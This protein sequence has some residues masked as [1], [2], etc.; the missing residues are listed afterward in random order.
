[1]VSDN[2]LPNWLPKML[3][4]ALSLAI[5]TVVISS[6]IRLADSGLGCTPWPD[7]YG[8]YLSNES[9]QGINVL[10]EEGDRSNYRTERIFHRL[11]ASSLGLVILF[12]FILSWR[13]LYRE[14]LGQFV[15]SILMLLTT[16]LAVI[17]PIRPATPLPILTVANFI[18]GL[19]IVALLY[20]LYQKL[21]KPKEIS[22][23]LGLSKYIGWGL[24]F[25]ILQIFF[26]GW[27]SANY[28][29]TSCE[30][31]LICDDIQHNEF[32]LI[33]AFNPV[34]SLQLDQ[35]SKVITESKMAII[36]FIHHLFAIFTLLYFSLIVV[37]L[38]KRQNQS[39]REVRK[40][41]LS[42]LGLLILQFLLGMS[43]L[44][45][46]LSITLVV[47]HNLFAALIFIAITSLYTK[48]SL[49]TSL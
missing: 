5:L 29:G 12:L 24:I 13:P 49:R 40:D 26:G 48:L 1:M 30:K 43:T 8:Q 21:T 44:A 28:A 36:Q 18:G 47:L 9:S 39:E 31:V 37:Y 22:V 33:D 20:Y 45:F 11:I 42:V 27:T 34:A 32:L 2:K 16:V 23:S 46:S 19:V 35:R 4:V 10:M 15:P 41:C 38:L 3:I 6:Y 17:G 14:K 25:I 7:C